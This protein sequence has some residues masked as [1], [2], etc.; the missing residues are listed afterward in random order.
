MQNTLPR[1]KRESLSREMYPMPNF[2]IEQPLFVYNRKGI[3]GSMVAHRD[4]ITVSCFVLL[5]LHL[6]VRREKVSK[7]TISLNNSIRI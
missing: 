5:I 1:L 7:T 6:L 4:P 2:R 3:G